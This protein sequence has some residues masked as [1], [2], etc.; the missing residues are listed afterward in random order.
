[1][2]T[3]RLVVLIFIVI[4]FGACA[5]VVIPL[6][7]H[8][9]ND[10]LEKAR[11]GEI[12]GLDPLSMFLAANTTRA[13][14]EVARRSPAEVVV[15]NLTVRPTSVDLSVE[16]PAEGSRRTFSVDPGFGVRSDKPSDAS[17]D[18]G[19]TFGRLDGTVPERMARIVLARV[20]R[21]PEALDYAV[22]SIP[23]TK[24]QPVT[25]LLYLKGGRVRD[26]GWTAGASGANVHRN[27]E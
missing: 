26:R 25:W 4:V 9:A 18:L 17:S 13:L 2:L 14:A 5:V 16:T 15:Q 1:V 6:E 21:G 8:Y 27:G 11:R 23:A 20:G 3:P 19:V 10:P 22:A 7:S 12:T 24:G